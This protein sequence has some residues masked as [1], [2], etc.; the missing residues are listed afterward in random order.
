MKNYSKNTLD[1]FKCFGIIPIKDV[2]FTV[3]FYE[4]N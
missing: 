1:P 4:D 2:T 3:S